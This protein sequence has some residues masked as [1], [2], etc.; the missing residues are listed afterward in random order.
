MVLML[1]KMMN[2][3][4][5]DLDESPNIGIIIENF[6][7]A[8]LEY[9]DDVSTFALGFEQQKRTLKAIN[10]FAIK[11]KLEWGVDKFKVMEIGSKKGKKV[12]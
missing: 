8:C 6:K 3:L 5:Q 4:P 10:E 9:V 2:T 11:H 1:Q 7:I 12:N